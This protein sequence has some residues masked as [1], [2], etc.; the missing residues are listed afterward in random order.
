MNV[1]FVCLGNICRSPI[2]EALLKKKYAEN[3]IDFDVDSAG[4]EPYHI[5]KPP[6]EKATNTAKFYG[7]RLTGRARL[8]VK[9]DFQQFD[10]IYAMDTQN[11]N[12]IRELAD[13]EED[14][15]K[16]DLIMNLIEPG[17][18]KTLP[19]PFHS[20]IDNCHTVFKKLDKATDKLLE[21]AKNLSMA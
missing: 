8:F 17:K 2:A 6:D 11:I 16:V 21:E 19:D 9:S 12:D 15:K 20:G 4:F 18:N 10:R 1:L 14:M 13:S 5:N 3:N 7:L